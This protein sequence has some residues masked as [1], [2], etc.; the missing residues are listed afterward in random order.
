[1][2]QFGLSTVRTIETLRDEGV[3]RMVAVIRHSAR[4]YRPDN[5]AAEGFL[6]LTEE[7][8][9]YSYRMGT[10]LPTDIELRLF[11]SPVGRCIET[12]YLIDKG[13]TAQGGQTETN[14]IQPKLAAFFVRDVGRIF[15]GMKQYGPTGFFRDWFKGNLPEDVMTN[16]DTAAERIIRFLIDLLDDNNS[17]GINI[18]VSHDW[19]MHVLKEYFLK[20]PLEEHGPVAYLEGAVLYRKNGDLF[21]SN[22]LAL[23][24]PVKTP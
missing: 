4:H 3:E 5:P 7:G 8:K 20:Q 16:P 9:D 11:S 19:Y 2:E 13:N 21:M 18:G 12:A 14:K 10:G 15:Q 6:G 24:Q 22:H 1:M 23:P 17:P